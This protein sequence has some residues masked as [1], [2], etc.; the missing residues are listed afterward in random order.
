MPIPESQLDAWSA[1]GAVAQSKATYAT[2]KATLEDKN[3]PY[4]GKSYSTFLQGSYRNDTNIYADS[5][6]HI[7]MMLDDMYCTGL[8]QLSDDDK[9]IYGS[10]RSSAGYSFKQF[11]SELIQQLSKSFGASVKPGK[12]V[13]FVSGSGSRRDSDVLACVE[14]RRYTRF[15]SFTD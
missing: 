12:K 2:I 11:K 13:I 15:E 3:A 8:S 10:A 1:Q 7:V 14:L 9:A 4:N 6:V 5:D